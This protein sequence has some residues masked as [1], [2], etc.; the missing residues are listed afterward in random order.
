MKERQVLVIMNLLKLSK[1]HVVSSF[2]N[3]PTFPSRGFSTGSAQ[4]ET[5][6]FTPGPNGLPAG[7]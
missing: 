1:E 6:N 3:Y 5:I 4:F 2:A 7:E